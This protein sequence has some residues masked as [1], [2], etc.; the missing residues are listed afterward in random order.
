VT[1]ASTAA[2]TDQPLASVSETRDAADTSSG[3]SVSVGDATWP[4]AAANDDELE[5]NVAPATSNNALLPPPFIISTPEEHVSF[6]YRVHTKLILYHDE[7]YIALNK[8][9]DLRMDGPHRATIHKLLL[10]LFPPPSLSNRK[11][12]SDDH[13]NNISHNNIRDNLDNDD[14]ENT[15]TTTILQQNHT[16]LLHSI[17]PLSSHS[18]LPDDPFRFI[19]QL[20]YA[21]SGVLLIGKTRKSTAVACKSFEERKTTKKYVAVVT[22][23]NNRLNSSIVSTTTS[24][25]TTTT[26]SSSSNNLLPPL[27]QDFFNNLPMVNS[28]LLDE[29]NDG[30]LE[31]QYKKKRQRETNPV[32]YLPIH[33]VFDKWRSTI[34]R[35]RK[36]ESVAQ[37]GG[38]DKLRKNSQNNHARTLRAPP[39]LLPNPKVPLTSEDEEEL[40]SLGTSWKAVKTNYLA[41]VDG[42]KRANKWID[43]VETMAMEYNRALDVYYTEQNRLHKNGDEDCGTKEYAA[44]EST[45]LSLPP[46]FRIRNDNNKTT[47]S[48]SYDGSSEEE[49][50]DSNN[51]TFYICASIGEIRGRFHVVVDPSISLSQQDR[52]MNNNSSMDSGGGRG[53]LPPLRPALTKCTV[54]SRG[55]YYDYSSSSTSNHDF[56]GEGEMQRIP[57]AKILLQPWTG[58][59]HQLRVH[60]ANIV[61]C[62]I[63]GDVAYDG[64]SGGDA[65]DTKTATKNN[66]ESTIANN[67]KVRRSVCRRMCLHARELTIPLMGGESKTFVAPDPFIFEDDNLVIL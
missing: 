24:V 29:W 50:E 37:G 62:P 34:I 23:S 31:Q 66:H 42:S 14:V 30:S 59:R 41:M 12:D 39:P 13:N 1:S 27:G 55:Y 63:L 60:L 8:P 33:S 56:N 58:R 16:Q 18:S 57:V 26:T 40:L 65:V 7:H 9:P 4:A 64:S 45:D 38:G 3:A 48:E 53:T 54:L 2:A 28:S 47:S 43:I 35:K 11:L 22:N 21:T 19:H 49:E 15:P 10:Y 6:F 25:T 67:N 5:N 20:D 36:E 32:R 44:T 52:M 46:M 51:S 61:G 17:N